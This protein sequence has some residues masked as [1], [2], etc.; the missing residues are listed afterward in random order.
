MSPCAQGIAIPWPLV[1]FL[2][3]I[4]PDPARLNQAPGPG[5]PTPG[6]WPVYR[7]PWCLVLV[8]VFVFV[9]T[10]WPVFVILDTNPRALVLVAWCALPGARSADLVAR[11]AS[12]GAWS[13]IRGQVAAIR[14]P[15]CLDRGPW[16]WCHAPWR[17]SERPPT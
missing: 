3:V 16:A 1:T 12:P 14:G 2:Q 5:R 13:A 4:R 17:E 9:S 11:L 7:A 8:A 15:W 10:W 6:P